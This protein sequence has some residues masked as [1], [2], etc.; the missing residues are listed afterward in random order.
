MPRLVMKFGGTSVATVDRIRNV[1]RHVAREVRAGYEVAVVVSAMS[2]KT[3]ELVAWCKDASP[4]YAQSEYD[5]VVASGEQVTSGLLAIVLA[6]M[7]IKARSWQGWQIPI[8]TSDQH[9]S[10]RIQN[11]DGARLDAGFK[12]GEVAVIAGF[13]GIHPETG[14]LTTLGRGGSDTSAVAIAAAIGAERCD[15]YTDV[16]GV[17]TTDPRVVPKAQRLERVAFEEMLEMASLGAKVLQVRSVELAMVHRV[18]TTVRSSFDDPD[19]ARPGTLIC[20]ED[21]I[22]EQQIITGIAFSKDE[23]QITLRRVKDKPGIAA[24]IFGPLAD[25]NI[26]VDMIIQVVSGD[27]AATDMTFTVPAADYERARAILEAQSGTVEVERIEGATDVVKVSAIGIGMRSHAGVAAKAFRALA[28]KGINIRAI[29]TSEIKFSVLI[30]AAYTELA[31]RTLH[32][33]YGLDKA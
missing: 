7:G 28:E 32:A 20:D 11:I 15:I 10:A 21:D 17:Y 8:E 4:L 16:D 24:A 5:A 12:R 30:D 3:N 26:N 14:R 23:A 25:A 6:E 9:G 29:T 18:P 31:V 22:V 1:A 33:L 19:D 27:G 2:G 13:Q